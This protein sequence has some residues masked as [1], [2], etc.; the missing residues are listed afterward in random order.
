LVS[1]RYESLCRTLFIRAN[2]NCPSVSRELLTHF[3]AVRIFE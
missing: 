3:C 1:K 2:L